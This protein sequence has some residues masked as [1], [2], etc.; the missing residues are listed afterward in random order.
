[1]DIAA[2]TKP[3][4]QA[5]AE[6][7]PQVLARIVLVALFIS[8]W[9]VLALLRMPMPTPF[10]MALVVEAALFLA[11]LALLP[12]LRTRTSLRRGSYLIFASEITLHTIMV[13]FLGGLN[14]LGSF[15]YVF[16]LIFTNAYLDMR[17]GFVYTT[18]AVGAFTLLIVLE[19]T[20]AIPHYEYLPQDA[21]R[22]KSP[23]FV[24]TTLIASWGVFFSVYAWVNWVGHRVRTERDHAVTLQDQLFRTHQ[25]L[26]AANS[27]L[28]QRVEQRTADL[29]AA[30]AAL[31]D[32][33]QLLRDTL[34]STADG[35]LV[36]DDQGRVVHSNAR[37]RAMWKIP[38]SL[39][40]SDDDEALIGYVLDQLA[41]P[42]A[43][44]AKVR[45]LYQSDEESF[46]VLHFKDGRVF[47][48][49][50]RP[51]VSQQALHGRVWSFRDVSDRKR[52]E[53]QLIH[54]ANEDPLTGLLNRRR[55]HEDLVQ[56]LAA[57]RRYGVAGAL[58]FIDLDQFKDVNDSLGHRAGDELLVEVA[59]LLKAALR[60]TDVVAR[61][62]GDEFGVLLPHTD[63]GEAMSLA[64]RILNAVRSRTFVGGGQ[65]LATSA[66]IGVALYPVHSTDADELLA[67]ADLAMYDAKSAGRGRIEV[68]EVDTERRHVIDSR[69]RWHQH[70]REALENDGFI[71]HAQPIAEVAS[72]KI[73]QYEMLIRAV[74]IDGTLIY[75]GEFL[76]IAERIGLIREID[77]WVVRKSIRMLKLLQ[78]RSPRLRLEV[79]LSA[80]A[81]GDERLVDSI[82]ADFSTTGADPSGLIFEVTETAAVR[83]L[84]QARQFIETLQSIG[85]Q[86]A[87]DDFGVGFSSFA[88]LKY[89]PVEYLKIDGS[90][91]RDLVNSDVDRHLVRAMV[92]AA[93]ALG[94][95]TIAE[96]VPDEATL[97]VLATLGV[98]HA[99][100]YGIGEPAPLPGVDDHLAPAA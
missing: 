7:I 91:V 3:V 76:P 83:D 97:A 2:A 70:L 50:S 60:D 25:D 15:A 81:F 33:E 10:L 58:L 65:H 61:L 30:M 52:F 32:G 44:V 96:Y 80:S 67:F 98:D 42:S 95:K 56:R 19:A 35:I 41:N 68:Y 24:A 74:D 87:L 9:V 8:L 64:S 79:N 5:R 82:R 17:R 46:D 49:F 20:S 11:Y 53:E 4:D 88:H 12:R 6:Q 38:D 94:K 1:M 26:Q 51:L 21:L 29:A 18:G 99:Q 16:G 85:C 43:F 84:E 92:T 27:L 22:F 66:S 77:R 89:L 75:P 40:A 72:G 36:V 28:E 69:V 73:T 57:S 54:L 14:W 31:Q 86:F 55:F 63:A 100:G 23:E 39:A 90:F 45:E 59:E 13:Y 47:E 62:G 71:L 48:R 37:F 93:K 78:E 34:E